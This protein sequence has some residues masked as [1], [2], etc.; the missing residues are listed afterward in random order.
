MNGP[1]TLRFKAECN[2]AV[3]IMSQIVKKGKIGGVEQKPVLGG[4]NTL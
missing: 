1:E 3:Q 4:V 2:N